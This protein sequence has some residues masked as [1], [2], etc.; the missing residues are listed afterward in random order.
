MTE[1]AFAVTANSTAAA[2]ATDHGIEVVSRKEILRR[3]GLGASG[4]VL[5]AAVPGVP[6]LTRAIA[7]PAYV[8]SRPHLILAYGGGTCE[9]AS[10]AGYEK[11]FFAADGLDVELLKMT[12]GLS[13][14]E[15]IASGKY[16]AAGGIIFTWL[17]PIEQ[18]ADIKV[19]AGIHGGCTSL[20]VANRVK[21]QIKKP[22]DFKG[23]TIAVTAIGDT[24]MA[25]FG[26][27]LSLHG[28]DINKDITWK[29]YLPTLI[30][31]AF[32]KGEV[33]AA[34]I[35]DPFAYLLIKHGKGV[36]VGTNL[37]G[38]FGDTTGM[39]PHK[40]CCTSGLSGKLIRDQPKV[41][42]ALTRGWINAARWVRTHLDEI[43]AIEV[44]K[45]YVPIDVASAGALLHSYVFNPS[46]IWVKEDIYAAA[47]AFKTAGIL[48][49][50][51]D[52]DKLAA[53]TYADVFAL[54]GEKAPF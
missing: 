5:A 49:L 35:G 33:D 53:W 31:A 39:T 14:A 11:G 52:P 1:R 37:L 50:H 36:A 48:D 26:L 47:R 4:A 16:D 30:E 45:N 46:A 7:G 19:T 22:S 41:A 18:G 3:A 24:G 34:A 21:S 23:K 28:V 17:K 2:V 9:A 13:G 25:F 51:T 10:F 29:V 8:P 40:Y 32:D 54:A 44:D 27:L 12:P 6:G 20:I 15:A 43:A 38:L 42:A